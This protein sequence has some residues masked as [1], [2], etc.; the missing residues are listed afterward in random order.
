M[1]NE[2]RVEA[3]PRGGEGAKAS[4]AV[5]LKNPK[6]DFAQDSY[7]GWPIAA[8]ID[9]N[10]A[11]GWSIDPAEGL[12]HVAVFETEKPLGFAQGTRLTF[13]MRHGEREHNLGCWRLAVTSARPTL[14]LPKGYGPKATIVRGQAPATTA[15]GLLV[16]TAE[17][18]R[19]GAPL[20]VPNVGNYFSA[21][22][23]LGGQNAAWTPVLGKATYPAPWQAWRIALPPA[24]GAKPFELDI[25]TT[26][27]GNIDWKYSAYFVPE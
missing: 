11:T 24:S 3:S 20:P 25:T 12:P 5:V 15:G 26:L 10:P 1:L 22:G 16:V 4:V 14:R 2:F 17:M 27:P 9:A 8:A 21:K 23:I 7:G 19:A 13:T 6:A 18:R